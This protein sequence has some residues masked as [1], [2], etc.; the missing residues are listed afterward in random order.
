MAPG[1]PPSAQRTLAGAGEEAFVALLRAADRLQHE[2]G[3][4]LRDEGDLT[5]VQYNVLRI[6]RGAGEDGQTCS[7]IAQRLIT[8]DPDVTRLID[9]MERRGLVRRG[10]D[11]NDRRVVRVHITEAGLRLVDTLDEPI[12]QFHRTRYRGLTM[13]QLRDLG[14]LLERMHAG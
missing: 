6:L 7:G 3:V 10:R 12:R 8:H 4:L 13:A 1:N 14:A 11:A 9:R 2:V 5:P